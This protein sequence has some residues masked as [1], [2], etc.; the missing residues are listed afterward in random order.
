MTPRPPVPDPAGPD[1]VT[2]GLVNNMPDGAL[3]STERQF[4]T[5]LSAAAG[6]RQ[7]RLRLFHLPE[8]P[9]GD[10]ALAILRDGYEDIGALWADDPVDGLIVTG[11]EP[12]TANMRDEPYWASLTGLVDWAAEHTISTV[13][14]CL[15]AHA[16]V[17]HRG[18]IAR[19]P[20]GAKLSGVFDCVKSAD[21]P[22]VAGLPM[23]WRMPHSRYNE[24]PEA[25]LAA[26][27]YQILSRSVEAGV[28]LFASEERSLFLYA[29]GHP[30]YDAG[31][32]L[33][34]Y[35]RD[36]ARFLAG[37]RQTYPDMPR[38]YFEAEPGAAFAEFRLRALGDPRA[39]L[40]REFP[41][42]GVAQTL[43]HAWRAPAVGLYANWLG[44]LCEQKAV[45]SRASRLQAPFP[46]AQAPDEQVST[47]WRP[48]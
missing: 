16:A 1:A 4:R 40:I 18:G 46:D 24:L 8:V 48:M 2:I 13:W 12:R 47:V 20:L 3:K 25:A 21:H 22:L 37:E 42:A 11:A 7:V 36:T 31:A 6:G 28:D 17:V 19:R 14:S 23:R 35:Q 27:G 43:S 9:R 5:L 44:Y 10:A 45:R 30:E 15:A 34:E 26:N 29:Q 33:R 41:A 32:L 38:F 39:D